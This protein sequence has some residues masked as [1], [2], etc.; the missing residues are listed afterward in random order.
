MDSDLIT[1]DRDMVI[2][3][4]IGAIITEIAVMPEAME[5]V[6]ISIAAFLIKPPVVVRPA[7]FEA[8]GIEIE[9]VTAIVIG[10]EIAIAIGIKVAP[11][12]AIH[13][14]PVHGVLPLKSVRTG[15]VPFKLMDPPCLGLELLAAAVGPRFDP[16]HQLL[17]LRSA[18]GHRQRGLNRG[19]LAKAERP[20]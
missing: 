14:G 7:L 16:R 8:T 5:A 20:K 1:L 13:Q 6:P 2:I 4:V 17:G 9:I 11:K 3:T 18:R 12:L 15:C 10:T 19:Q